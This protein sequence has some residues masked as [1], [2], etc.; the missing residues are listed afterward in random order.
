MAFLRLAVE[1]AAL[2]VIERR[3]AERQRRLDRIPAAADD[4]DVGGVVGAGG[5][6][7]GA[8]V[9]DAFVNG[10]HFAGAGGHEHDVHQLLLDDLLMMSRNSA[11]LR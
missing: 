3:R 10:Q 5:R 9:E 6:R 2:D 11:E 7:D 1:M 8:V 4:M